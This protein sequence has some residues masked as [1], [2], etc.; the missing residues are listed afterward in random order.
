ML[1]S[2]MSR[3]ATL[4]STTQKKTQYVWLAYLAA[5]GRT[6]QHLAVQSLLEVTSTGNTGG[7]RNVETAGQQLERHRYSAPNVPA[8][9]SAPFL[10]Q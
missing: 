9:R 6:Y 4:G 8:Q 2:L 3:L 1:S 5:A 7:Q 10:W